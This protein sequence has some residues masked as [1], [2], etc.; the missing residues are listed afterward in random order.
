M[1]AEYRPSRLIWLLGLI[2][3]A[4]SVA[5]IAWYLQLGPGGSGSSLA[6]NDAAREPVVALGHVE[7]QSIDPRGGGV[8]RGV[9]SL[10]PTQPG[11]VVQVLVS[12]GQ[13]VSSAGVPL[14]RLDDR[15][16]RLRRDE[17]EA[18]LAAFQALRQLAERAEAQHEFRLRQQEAAVTVA[19]QTHRGAEAEY[20]RQKKHHDAGSITEEQL[21]LADAQRL[22]AAALVDAEK[23]RLKELQGSAL[24]LR[25][26]ISRAAAE[27]E[28][29]QARLGQA[30]LA[31][32]ECELRS[33]GAGRVL[34]LQAGIGDLLSSAPLQ[35]A[36][37]FR[38]EG[39]L[40]IRAEVAQ[41]D[42]ARV[43]KGAA[44][45]I[46]DETESTPRW[47]GEVEQVSEWLA[48]RRSTLLEPGELND[49][50]TL[51]CIIKLRSDDGLRLGQRVR[52]HI[53]P[54]PPL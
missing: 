47:Q 46:H 22:K 1:A 3:L 4:A 26:A 13:P 50:R 42:A 36:V 12:E 5:G 21:T 8:S 27:V 43:E 41:E 44:V 10:F 49:V 20:R 33:P 9:I 38:P 39:P 17:A 24:E 23:A 45:E 48:R 37:L 53:R 31:V 6:S 40:V 14:L 30:R 15:L 34:R 25:L 29:A 28:A 54:R 18:A 52:V 7:V 51:E 35:P 19:E 32:D 11:R 16:A 2:V